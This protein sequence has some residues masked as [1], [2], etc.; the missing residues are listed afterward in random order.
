MMKLIV[1]LFF[2]KIVNS[3]TTPPP[4]SFYPT[5]LN[6]FNY[7]NSFSLFGGANVISGS[8]CDYNGDGNI[9]FIKSDMNLGILIYIGEPM[10]NQVTNHSIRFTGLGFNYAI[11]CS[12]VNNDGK[13]DIIVEDSTTINSGR[14]VVIYG[15]DFPS[16]SPESPLTYS[17]TYVY[18]NAQN[19]FWIKGF[20]S[21]SDYGY[22]ISVGDFNG[23]SIN[24]LIFG[25][26]SQIGGIFFLFGV[27]NTIFPT[28]STSSEFDLSTLNGTNGFS[29]PGKASSS[30][31]TG[32]IND[33]N[34]IDVM[35]CTNPYNIFSIIYGFS[36]PLPNGVYSPLYDGFTSFIISTP[37]YSLGGYNANG[38]G[39]NDVNGDGINDIVFV[40]R[41]A[42]K[43]RV[44]V[45]NGK[46]S[47][48]STL[49]IG[50]DIDSS[51]GYKIVDATPD[52]GTL[53]TAL[54]VYDVNGDGLA[55]II[56]NGGVP[57]PT[58]N[59]FVIFSSFYQ[60]PNP[61]S[62]S[63]P[64]LNSTSP[65]VDQC[66]GYYMNNVNVAFS[67]G[68]INNDGVFDIPIT[69]NS[70]NTTYTLFGRSY[71][72]IML[73]SSSSSSSSSSL[74]SL[75]STS[76]VIKYNDTTSSVN[77]KLF[78]PI[79]INETGVCNIQLLE[80]NIKNFTIGDKLQFNNGNDSL[81]NQTQINDGQIKILAQNS[82]L[83]SLGNITL[84]TNRNLSDIIVTLKFSG[85]KDIIE[86][87]FE[88]I[89]PQSSSSSDSSTIG[90]SSDSSTLGSSSS[91]SSTIGNS[92]DS[93]TLGSSSS[94]SS[95]LG[96]S[97]SDSSILDSSS[98]DSS[99]SS[100]SSST[101]SSS[102]TS[103]TSSQSSSSS[104]SNNDSKKRNIGVIIGP[105]IGGAG[106][107]LLLAFGIF[108]LKRKKK[109]KKKDSVP[110]LKNEV[111]MLPIFQGGEI[112]KIDK[113]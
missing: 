21:F 65:L 54:L 68:D 4:S 105:I 73:S 58:F 1:L 2:I 102:S 22:T 99:L 59:Y 48:P 84:T 30:M 35:F 11:Q 53:C 89:P 95:T 44:N 47:Y 64:S 31:A 87:S 57:A 8:F 40:S 14:I 56:C 24:D 28:I 29:I 16:A 76:I 10:T 74:S 61:L 49:T 6:Q 26:R 69:S 90:N 50:Q 23:D 78:D 15:K 77:Y 75:S 32:Y 103:S 97:S 62:I 52:L 98:S 17:N 37:G 110:T 86:I 101:D 109:D 45:V 42:D 38:I 104:S 39:I 111:S 85:V 66:K 12:D 113:Y 46:S 60:S 63:N 94:D 9:D 72:E 19:G 107:V 79:V 18:N 20:S 70:F 96:S 112:I 108:F 27:N 81:Y 7:S 13:D 25:S 100:S 5:S 43:F 55:D 91:D 106:L 80:I 3:I 67:L 71:F 51:V 92:S 93:S 82:L 36:D 41:G 34:L 83:N 33:D 88:Y